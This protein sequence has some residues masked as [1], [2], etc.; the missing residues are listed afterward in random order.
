MLGALSLSTVSTVNIYGARQV[1][2]ESCTCGVARTQS[3][4]SSDCKTR[5]VLLNHALVLVPGETFP[6]K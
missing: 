6:L 4:C 1:Q 2:V 5:F 3:V